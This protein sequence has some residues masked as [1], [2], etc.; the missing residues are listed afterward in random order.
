MASTDEELI[1]ASIIIKSRS[2]Y[3]KDMILLHSRIKSFD[4]ANLNIKQTPEQLAEAGFYYMGSEDKCV[5]YYC[6]LGVYKWQPEDDPWFEHALLSDIC[7]FL[8]LKKS[9]LKFQLGETHP[10]LA[11]TTT[12]DPL[13][14]YLCKICK[15]SQANHV[16]IPC[17]HLVSCLECTTTQ[18]TCAVCRMYID[19]FVK[20]FI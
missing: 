9:D 15:T 10:T 12:S 1:V 20:I 4:G 8:N 18:D 2:I 11:V 16:N 6:G 19:G 13:D 17:R 7:E 3:N 14:I 5:C